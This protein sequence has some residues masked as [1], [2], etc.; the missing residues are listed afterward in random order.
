VRI[1]A[2]WKIGQIDERRA[3]ALR[4]DRTICRIATNNL[5]YLDVKPM[6]RVQTL[7][8]FKHSPLDR[9]GGGRA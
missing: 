9:R 4:L 3:A 7:S 8:G 2:E 1:A 6:G 5:R